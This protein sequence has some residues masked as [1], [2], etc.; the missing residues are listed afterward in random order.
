MTT[1]VKEEVIDKP[2]PTQ[3][4]EETEVKVEAETEKTAN[5]DFKANDEKEAKAGEVKED[6]MEVTEEKSKEGNKSENECM[7]IELIVEVRIK[8]VRLKGP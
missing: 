2:E 5:G 3:E 6:G 4:E 1:F 8:V 7:E